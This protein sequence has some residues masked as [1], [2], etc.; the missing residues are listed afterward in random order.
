MKEFFRNYSVVLL[1]ALALGLL[2]VLPHLL[3]V[4]T[5]GV[6][7]QGIPFMY[8]DDE[9]I[10]LARMQEIIDGHPA[11]GSIFLYEY[12]NGFATQRS[13]GELF[14][15]G[16]SRITGLT[17]PQT[18][19]LAKFLFPILLF[20]FV[21]SFLLKIL[22]ADDLSL[23]KIWAL[24][25]STLVA[26]GFDLLS[27]RDL[28]TVLRGQ[29]IG[30]Q[31]SIW[32]RPVNPILGALF[33]FGYLNLLWK[34]IFNRKRWFTVAAGVLLGGS[35]F[36][37]FCWGAIFS[38]TVVLGTIFLVQK[39]WSRIKDVAI[40]I[41]IGFIVSAPYW[42]STLRSIGGEAGRTI[43]LRNG[44]FFTHSPLMNKTLFAALVVFLLISAYLVRRGKIWR[45]LAREPW[46]F[47]MLSLLLGGL[48]ALNQQIVTGR[49]IWPYH[50]VQYTKPFAMIVVVVTLSHLGKF[51]SKLFNSLGVIVLFTLFVQGVAVAST[52]RAV[53]PDFR[54][55]QTEA[56]VYEWINKNAEKDCVV[57]V[58]SSGERMARQIPAF[59]S[60]NVY[61]VYWLIDGI[62]AERIKH[63]FF[64]FLRLEGVDPENA[65]AYLREHHS[66]VRG[67]FYEDW[68]QMFKI[69]PDEW[70]D[71][72]AAELA[73]EYQEFAKQPF[74]QELLRYRL[75]Y[76]LTD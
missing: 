6:E 25:G 55:R 53:L 23:R 11:L 68:D 43:A 28:F 72:K 75:D 64:V 35:V 3:A 66:L 73:P 16:L 37:F 56:S 7:Y 47:V 32:T 33:V 71:G 24:V 4:R 57:L 15:V 69:T 34:G 44:M 59:T 31:L 70:S 42:I 45:E 52:Y 38:V 48:L 27:M 19:V 67:Y 8:S 10:Y 21:Y 76:V 2:S 49:E 40:T 36:Y 62:P 22:P 50:F 46:W 65:E 63:N 12:K 9:D 1:C 60:C 74:T 13:Y 18:L 54:D 26:L 20:L 41:G 30:L 58:V 39:D 5:L 17:L 29:D 51:R 14:Y 61:G